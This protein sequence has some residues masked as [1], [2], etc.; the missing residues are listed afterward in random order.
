VRS[1]TTARFRKLLEALPSEVQDRAFEAYRQF[2]ADPFHPSLRFKRVHPSLPLYSARVS[3]GYR[4]VG[5][6]EGDMIIWFWIGTHAQYD[7][8]IA[9]R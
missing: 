4:A 3:K 6:H 2:E 9:R 1:K 5:Q 8:L 7:A